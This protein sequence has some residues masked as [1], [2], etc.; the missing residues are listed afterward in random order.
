MAIVKQPAHQQTQAGGNFDR[1]MSRMSG[2]GYRPFCPDQATAQSV[3][4]LRHA[5]QPDAHWLARSG[6][7]DVVIGAFSIGVLLGMAIG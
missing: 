5:G 6:R 4:C 2:Q 3:R 7:V 1:A